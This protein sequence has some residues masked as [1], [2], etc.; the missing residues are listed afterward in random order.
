M[1]LITHTDWIPNGIV[2]ASEKD[3]SGDTDP[4]V[5]EFFEI[6]YVLSGTGV[7][8]IDGTPY[9]MTPGSLFFLSPTGTHAVRAAD[10]RIINVMFRFPDGEEALP[11]M[12]ASTCLPLDAGDAALVH[13]LLR[14]LVATHTEDLSYARCILS[15][16]LRKL[17][18]VSG[19]ES[20]DALS[21]VRSAIRYVT[22][23]FRA[24][25]TLK[26]TADRL[27]LTPTYFSALFRAET[28][29][30]F[31]Q[32]LDGVR[33]SHAKGLLTFTEIPICEIPSL[34]G[35][36]DYANFARRFKAELGV[37][38]SAWRASHRKAR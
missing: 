2:A 22:E 13:A 9:P 24:G 30:S 6:E 3:L 33:F 10:A 36:G 28:G 25:I 11:G 5:H 21:Y 26:S 1:K 19:E 35:F 7:C 31:K 37:T 32:Y 14:E 16:L 29:M 17:S 23:S 18:R 27:G 15:V 8:E 4:H 20:L 38:P 34:S 12:L